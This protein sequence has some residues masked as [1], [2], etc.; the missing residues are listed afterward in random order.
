M[1]NKQKTKNLLNNLK[2]FNQQRFH[3]NSGE[4]DWKKIIKFSI[5][6]IIALIISFG[7]LITLT[8]AFLSIGLPDVKDLDNLSLAQSTTIYDRNGNVLYVKYGEENREYKKLNQISG[9]IIK[10][11]LA[12]E[13]ARFYEHSGFDIIGLARAVVHDIT[14][15]NKQGGSTITQQ[16]IKLTFLSSEKSVT[17]KIKELI[18][19]V[20]LEKAFDKDTILEKYLNKIPYGNNAFGVEKAAQTYFNKSAK[21][22]TLAEAAILAGIPQMPSYYNPYGPNRYS[23]L[24]SSIDPES[25]IKRSIKS[26]SD[27][28]DKEIKRG[29]IGSN[30]DIGGGKTIYIQ[31]RSDIVLKRMIDANSITELE[32]E[33][34]LAE[35][36]KIEF[37]KYKQSIKAPHFVFYVIQELESKYGKELVE[38]GGLKVYTTLDPKLQDIAEEAISSRSESYEKN[39]N[40]KNTALVSLNPENSQILAMI[41]SRN[42]FDTEIDGQTNIITSFRQPG[43]TF[44]PIVYASAFINRYSPASIIFDVSTPFGASWPKNYDG[45]FQ[46]PISLRVALAQSRNIPAIKSYFLGGEQ[47]QIV[48]LAESLGVKFL[49]RDSEFGYPLSL[50]A[51][52][53]TLLSM[54]NAYATFANQGIHNSP[55]AI[56]R[57]ENAQG[58]LLEEWKPTEKQIPV[59]DPQVA[60]LI[61]SILSD[62][63]VNV[64][65]NLNVNGQINAAK[66]GTSNR[67]IG[68]QYLPNDL[69]TIG[70]TTKLVTAVWGGNNDTTKDGNLR[71]NADGYNVAAPIFKEFMEKGLSGNPAE[72]FPIPEGIRQETVSKYSGKL[73]SNLTPIDAH[74]T[75][76][77]A[78]WAVP[79]EMD[80]SYSGIPDFS[81]SEKLS[82]N[83]CQN[84]QAQLLYK[85]VLHDID[86][87][88]EVWEEY[89]QKWLS[90]NADI[91]NQQIGKIEC[92]NISQDQTPN[93]EIVNLQ[94]NQIL[95][96]KNFTVQIKISPNI[97]AKQALFYIDNSLQYNQDQAPFSGNIRIP[98]DENQFSHK[99]TILL[100]DINGNIG[101]KTITIKTHQDSDSNNLSSNNMENN[102]STEPSSNHSNDPINEPIEQ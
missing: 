90:E 30:V 52:E 43:S 95:F 35:I 98:R 46:G 79:T 4:L 101:S 16:Y 27:L 13:D 84:G 77:F 19:A 9:N 71:A 60:Y 74:I 32:K 34:A 6:G 75:D 39:Y 25:L 10:A 53:T 81:A 45:K 21:D 56:L 64:G 55:V 11:T 40:V 23:S 100:Y 66:T 91:L 83:T 48:P 78:S 80:E 49:D 59:I 17:R 51:G 36:Q 68:N 31:G 24:A 41:G 12:V 76:Y 47:K 20:R 86:P 3:K 58:Q 97:K 93:F 8:I 96:D 69:L 62:R 57:V 61:T 94:D 44:K 15:G 72:E 14:T 89:A 28:K 92:A 18:L 85:S 65:S 37:N 63:S 1:L 73:V 88:R 82:P 38:Q 50:G 2:R 29:L 26:E 5:Y 42:Y 70:Y 33:Q 7:I 102:N 99:L 22:V 54:A 87:N 67:K